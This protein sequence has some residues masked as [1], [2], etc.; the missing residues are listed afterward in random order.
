M[1][2]KQR[3][4]TALDRSGLP[5]RLPVTTHHLMRYFLDTYMGGMDNEAFFDYFGLDPIRWIL[6]YRADEAAGEYLDPER[7]D[8]L[9][10]CAIL[11]DTWQLKR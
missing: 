11:T 10:P 4:L 2:A 8:P 1:N 9:Q 5:D 7:E 3:F 6:P